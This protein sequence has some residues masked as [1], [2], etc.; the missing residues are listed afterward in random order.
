MKSVCTVTRKSL[1]KCHSGLTPIFWM[2]NCSLNRRKTIDSHQFNIK[3]IY[4]TRRLD[5]V[6]RGGVKMKERRKE[7]KKGN[8]KC[9]A[10]PDVLQVTKIALQNLQLP[11]L[12]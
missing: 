10:D 1:S 2:D 11:M 12:R 7:E 5:G 3:L 8:V 9:K 6:A 4:A